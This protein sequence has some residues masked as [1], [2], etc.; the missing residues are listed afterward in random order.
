[1]RDMRIR[2]MVWTAIRS[3]R[4]GAVLALVAV[5]LVAL[6]SVIALA[7]DLGMLYAAR[8]EAQRAADSAALAGAS[9][10]L[11][12][13]P[14]T[15][16][17]EAEAVAHARAMDYATRH[18]VMNFPIENEEV[19]PEIILAQEMVRVTIRRQAV[20]LFFA[21]IFGMSSS[22]VTATAVAV[23]SPE[24]AGRVQCVKPFAL[25]NMWPNTNP[26]DDIYR[27]DSQAPVW[28]FDAHLHPTDEMIGSGLCS[29]QGNRWECPP[30]VW[31]YDGGYTGEH[32]Y[33][34]DYR[35]G[36]QDYLGRTYTQD[37]GRRVPMKIN[38]PTDGPQSSFWFPWRIDQGG[39]K[40]YTELLKGCID[41]ADIGQEVAIDGVETENGNF[42]K[43][44]YDAIIDLIDK[45]NGTGAPDPDAYWDEETN[46]VV[47]PVY[48]ANWKASPRVITVALFNPGDMR[49][50]HTTMRFVDFASFFLEDPR[51]VY[52]DINPA[53]HAPITGRYMALVSGTSGAVEDG[54]PKRLRLV[55]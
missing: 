21:R 17:V 33:G 1:M 16:P 40:A 32:G 41:A 29:R 2:S 10:F 53:H 27:R 20:P 49:A 18:T 42:P 12:I 22:G 48:G 54:T 11:D 3:D 31:R 6:V 52:P 34:S 24:D 38:F 28:D 44:T 19:E 13:N 30:E 50:G 47:S 35:N 51:V 36:A 7:V 14:A 39:T 8:G 45:G 43:P 55:Q 9:A 23:A 37:E 26:A 5:S 25:P 46:S 15:K 4:P